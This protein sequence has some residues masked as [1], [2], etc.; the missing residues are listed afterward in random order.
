M[1]TDPLARAPRFVGLEAL[2]GVAILAVFLFHCVLEFNTGGRGWLGDVN[3]QRYAY[4][5]PQHLGDFGV[6]L[7]FVVSGFCIHHATTTWRTHHPLASVRAL[8]LAYA[9]RRFWRIY[10]L[11]LLAMMAAFLLQPDDVSAH[12]G[13]TD[14][15]VH[16]ALLQ[17]LVPEHINRINPSL[18]SVAVEVQL[19]ALYP[20][21]SWALRRFDARMVLA[22][23]ALL[24]LS[25]RLGLPMTDAPEWLQNF[26]PRWGFAWVLGV[27][28]AHG[29]HGTRWPPGRIVLALAVLSS[30]LLTATR[31]EVVYQTVP[32]LLF[33]LVVAWAVRRPLHDA[34]WLGLLTALGGVSYAVYLVH[35]PLLTWL[36]RTLHAAGVRTVDPGPFFLASAVSLLASLVLAMPL[37]RGYRRWMP[38][39]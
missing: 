4:F 12:R 2:R 25:W 29:Q 17:T 14:L 21:I 7:F 26:A 19:Y 15:A 27:G 33:A 38:R 34:N 37:E 30:V 13:L 36:A 6:Q 11:Y 3:S 1:T 35:Q 22:A 5:V 16:A 10:P 24:T 28:V 9:K 39:A 20:L 31:A 23:A 8:W 18:W 32:P